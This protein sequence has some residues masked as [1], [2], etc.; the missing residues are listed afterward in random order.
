MP[1]MHTPA[2]DSTFKAP[3]FTGL[4]G[5]DGKTYG[6]DDVR[7][8]AG[9]M[10]MF[11]CNHCPYVQAVADRLAPTATALERLGVGVVAIMPND[12]GA[13]PDDSFDNMRTF[14]RARN[15]TFPYV[16]DSTQQVAKAY[17]AVCTPDFFGFD[18][19]LNLVYRGRLDS[20]GKGPQTADT[21]PELVNAMAE[22][23]AGRGA[24]QPQVPSMGCSIK[25]AD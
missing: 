4:A 15:F 12:T 3:P 13:Y 16:W 2:L 19:G 5:V 6:L 11:I 17:G 1:L 21:I 10:V 23:V 25:W 24:P 9:L 8:P 22:V 7:G 20:A 14:A 18:A